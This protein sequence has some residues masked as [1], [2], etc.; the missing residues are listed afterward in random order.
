MTR[1]YQDLGNA[2]D[3]SCHVGNLIQPITSTTQIL[4]VT[5]RQSGISALV[6]QTSFGGETN[7]NVAKCK[8]FSLASFHV[9]FCLFLRLPS[10]NR[11]HF[12]MV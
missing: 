6:Y 4:G 7:G 5:R 1:H 10:L 11:A 3:W 8:L 12:G 9:F 2:S